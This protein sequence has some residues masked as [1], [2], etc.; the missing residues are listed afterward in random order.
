MLYHMVM[1][2]R[3]VLVQLEDDLVEGLDELAN[4]TG[5]SRSELL[6]RGAAAILEADQ[7][8]RDDQRL[9]AAYLETPPEPALLES[10]RRLGAENSPEW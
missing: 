5:V 9:V 6:R 3:Q 8:T 1:A 7:L 10:S 2:R 4:R